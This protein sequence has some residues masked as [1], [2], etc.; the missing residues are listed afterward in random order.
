MGSTILNRITGAGIMLDLQ[1][2][3]GNCTKE[4]SATR[5]GAC[6]LPQAAATR[7]FCRRPLLFG[8]ADGMATHF[9]YNGFAVQQPQCSEAKRRSV[10][11]GWLGGNFPYEN[12]SFVMKFATTLAI[13]P[14]KRDPITL[15]I[16]TLFRLLAFS[17][18]RSSP[19][20]N[21]T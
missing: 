2:G 8:A 5:N 17:I 3:A 6:P 12:K 16:V 18:C 15:A 13:T 11:N 20:V 7:L 4:L 21:R 19:E 14:S 10:C 9:L 1:P